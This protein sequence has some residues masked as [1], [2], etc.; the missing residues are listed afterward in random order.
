M[1]RK[2]VFWII[3]SA[4]LIWGL[5]LFLFSW[6]VPKMSYA[7][8]PQKWKHLPVMQSRNILHDY[9][10]TPE[11]LSGTNNRETWIAGSSA[12]QYR[13]SVYYLNDTLVG[14][15]A[16]HYRLQKKWISRSFLVDTVSV[17]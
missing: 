3:L 15:Y 13:L 5:W 9:L 2:I 12:K 10:G 16:I 8:I 1:K 14:S 4:L 17:R 11:E 7:A 6:V